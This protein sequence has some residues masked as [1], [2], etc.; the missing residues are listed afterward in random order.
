MGT[1]IRKGDLVEVIF[2]KQ[3]PRKGNPGTRGRVLQV[4]PEKGL[5]L[6]E[7]VN[8]RTK[9]RRQTKDKAGNVYGGKQEAEVAIPVSRVALVDPKT[10]KPTRVGIKLNE[11][12]E[13]I[14]V[15]RTKSTGTELPSAR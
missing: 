4:M 3:G 13:K 7:G 10:D 2:G 9:H 1:K 12:G 8:V 6:V 11:K 15:A 5:V 14:R